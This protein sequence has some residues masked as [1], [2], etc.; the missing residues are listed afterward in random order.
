[1][2]GTP[3]PQSQRLRRFKADRIQQVRLL[4]T[5]TGSLMRQTW[6]PHFQLAQPPTG[7]CGAEQKVNQ[8][9]PE[10]PQAATYT[11]QLSTGYKAKEKGWHR[12]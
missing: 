12:E 11:D 5:T 9:T 10:L 8:A 4:N 1:M 3:L 6:V 7:P 2:L